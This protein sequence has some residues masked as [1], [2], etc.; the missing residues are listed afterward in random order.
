MKICTF[1]SGSSGNSF[2]LESRHSKILIDAGISLRRISR[3]LQSIGSEVN[4]IDAVILSHE[5][6][7][8]SKGVWRMPRVPVYVSEE[9]VDFWEGKKRAKK[10]EYNG[11][12]RKT[13]SGM[14]VIKQFDSQSAFEIKD[15]Q[16][17]PFAVAHDAIDP[18]GFTVTDGQVKVGVVTDIGKPT[19]LVIESLKNCDVLVIESNYNRDALFSGPYPAYLK[20][21]ISG[22]HGHLSN[23]QSASLLEEVMH[24]GLK[25]VLLA[26]L[27][28]KNNTAEMALQVSLDVLRRNGACG[29]V[30][31][32]VAPRNEPSEVIEI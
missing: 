10:S 22:G 29:Y 6:D 28:A 20:Q 3:N 12:T 23:E 1:A 7:D 26:H 4:D 5:H 32:M 8:H 2:Y 13:Q 18:V 11:G 30:S 16:I 21:R 15:L 27:S 24:K 25:H 17:T 14:E 9:T 31:L 19:A